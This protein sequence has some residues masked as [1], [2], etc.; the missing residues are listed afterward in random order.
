MKLL[1]CIDDTDNLNSK[2]TGAIADE[3]KVLIK[4]MLGYECGFVT[5]HQLLIHEDI[6]YTSHNSSM[7]FPCEIEEKDYDRLVSLC[8]EHLKKESAQ[9]SDPGLAVAVLGKADEAML[10][11]YGKDAKRKII[12]KNDAYAVAKKADV[13]LNEAG[14]TGDGIIGALAGIGLRLWGNDGT[15]KG[16][17]P[18]FA[19]GQTYS[20]K[21]FTDTG[22]IS[23][24]Q[25]EEGNPLSPD[26][27][28]LVGWK[29]K[30]SMIN[31]KLTLLVK[32]QDGKWAVMDKQEMRDFSGNRIFAEGCQN[33]KPDVEEE[34]ISNEKC[35]CFNCRYRR[36]LKNGLLCQYNKN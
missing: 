5:R 14:G 18:Q 11:A 32:K 3:L 36:W 17:L 8:F 21:E 22:M 28:I 29:A 27:Q 9:G 7:C 35:S 33:F 2:G 30:P 25:D 34:Q 16:Q 31:G 4:F 20:V 19:E 24:V 6:P 10:I 1:I 26:E 15:L 13:Y 23:S 12:H